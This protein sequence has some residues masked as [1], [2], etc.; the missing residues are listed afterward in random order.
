[1]T[2]TNLTPPV[3]SGTPRSGQTLTTTAGTWDWDEANNTLDIDYR[4][5]RC[6]ASG[7]NCTGIANATSTTYTLTASDIG[8]T[9]RSEV[10]ATEVPSAPPPPSGT[11]IPGTGIISAGGT[12]TSDPFTGQITISTTQPVTI[13]NSTL[14][15]KGG[16]LIRTSGGTP[17]NLTLHNCTIDGAS[18][19]ILDCDSF[20]SI[21]MINCSIEKTSGITLVGNGNVSLLYNRHHNIQRVSGGVG[22]FLQVRLYQTGNFEVAWNEIVNEYNQSDPEDIFSIYHSSNTWWHHNYLQGQFHPGNGSGSSQNGI[23]LDGYGGS[24]QPVNNNVIEENILVRTL[25]IAVFPTSTGPAANNMFRN[26]RYTNAGFLDDGT[27]RNYYGY[28]GMSVKPGGTNNQA[29]G[30]VLGAMK[31]TSQGSGRGND[32]EFSGEPRGNG[33]GSTTGA[34]ADNYH[35]APV[36]GTITRAMEDDEWDLWQSRLTSEGITIGAS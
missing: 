10:T 1:M 20:S 34:W 15:Y 6:D 23:T 18:H 19:R 7:L 14:T 26:N 33:N 29:H 27:T 32:G 16:T 21:T 12:Y 31:G 4:W 35:M 17:P 11:P 9:I 30:N 22:N 28:Q 25:S 2:V 8:S 24:G 5:L 36:G 13:V 3:V